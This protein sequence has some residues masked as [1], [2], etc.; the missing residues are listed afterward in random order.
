MFLPPNT[1]CLIQPLD[2]GII[3]AFKAIYKKLFA[4]WVIAQI[5]NGR[6]H[7]C[8]P[9]IRQ[10]IEWSVTA[11]NE[12]TPQTVANCWRHGGILPP[13]EGDSVP[14]VIAGGKLLVAQE[15]RARQELQAELI[16]LQIG[17]PLDWLKSMLGTSIAAGGKQIAD[18]L[19]DAEEECTNADVPRAP[20]VDGDDNVA[21]GIIAA[22]VEVEE[23]EVIEGVPEYEEEETPPLPPVTGKDAATA[24]RAALSYVSER[25][26]SSLTKNYMAGIEEALWAIEK[27]MSN[28]KK[29]SSLS[30]FFRP[31]SDE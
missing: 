7:E 14:S 30:N 20:L 9:T 2:Q 31:R 23:P 4:R 1:T 18:L 10:A 11:W 16:H 22:G 29:Q 26:E 25:P 27:E 19:L 13:L 15:K 21:L 5:D 17:D 12:I 24:L 3:R 28:A 6:A 8:T